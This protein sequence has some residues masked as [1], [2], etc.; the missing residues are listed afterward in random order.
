MQMHKQDNLVYDKKYV[1]KFKILK[2][3]LGKM[4]QPSPPK[5]SSPIFT[6]L[7]LP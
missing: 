3:N 5:N 7:Q 4:F 6:D 2:M 1:L